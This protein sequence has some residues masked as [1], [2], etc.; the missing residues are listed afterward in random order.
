MW[1]GYIFYDSSSMTLEK[2]QNYGDSK[3]LRVAGSEQGGSNEISTEI[4]SAVNCA[5]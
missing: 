2:R 4:H 3:E 1:K 5:V